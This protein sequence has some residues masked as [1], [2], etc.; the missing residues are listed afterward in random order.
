MK[1]FIEICVEKI[2][3]DHPKTDEFTIVI[4]SKRARKYFFEAFVNL[5]NQP[6]Y[7]PEIITIDELIHN[8][9]KLPIIDKTRQ[10]FVLYQVASRKK[11]F[12]ALKFETFL[13]GE[14]P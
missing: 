5:F 14:I 3:A 2:I 7:L 13:S 10:L 9:T 12:H 4:P 1:T 6:I 11:E 8:S